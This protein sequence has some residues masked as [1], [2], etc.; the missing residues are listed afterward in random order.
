[1]FYISGKE[2]KGERREF[3]FMMESSLSIFLNSAPLLPIPGQGNPHVT[4]DKMEPPFSSFFLIPHWWI[5]TSDFQCSLSIFFSVH[6]FMIQN[7]WLGD[8]T[9]LSIWVHPL[10]GWLLLNQAGLFFQGKLNW[11]T[12]SCPAISLAINSKQQK[13]IPSSPEEL[14]CRHCQGLE[15]T[16]KVGAGLRQPRASKMLHLVAKMTGID[17]LPSPD[18]M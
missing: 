2:A 8:L 5:N 11:Q 17:Y 4:K 3:R 7:V 1:M 6:C 10:Q 16:P 12:L 13:A 9:L 14:Y 15:S 18:L